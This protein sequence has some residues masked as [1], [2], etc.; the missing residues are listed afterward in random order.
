MPVNTKELNEHE[1]KEIMN[2]N[3]SIGS[4]KGKKLQEKK[5]TIFYLDLLLKA[6]VTT[7]DSY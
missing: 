2:H 5:R 4:I 3:Y 7:V 1:T 6:Q